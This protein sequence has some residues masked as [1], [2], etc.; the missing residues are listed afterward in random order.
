M[1]LIPALIAASIAA[2]PAPPTEPPPAPTTDA[3]D[4]LTARVDD[5]A[6]Q[7]FAQLWRDTDGKPTADQIEERYLRDGGRGVEVF[8]PYRIRN[9]EHLAATVAESP[10][11]YRNAVER[12]LPWVADTNA[13]LRASYLALR[14]L[15]PDQPLP[16][17]AVVIG[18]GNSG[19]TADTGIQVIGL[20]VLCRL[21]PTRELFNGKMRQF[22]A[23]ETVHTFQPRPS[24]EARKNPLLASALV[25]GVADYITDVVTARVPDAERDTWARAREAQV[26]RDFQHD[27]AI[28]QAGM[29]SDG[30][31]TP[32]AE[33]AY[34]RWFGNA[35][36]P[37]E[38]WPSELGYWVG[39]RIA[40]SYVAQAKDPHKAID[41][42]I[43]AADPAA[44]LADSGYG[45]DFAR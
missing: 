22:F 5:S 19:G 38:G 1:V 15:L 31:A 17:I 6:A 26:W 44:I 4:P 39:M 18:A 33:A 12:C 24:A 20:E 28:V 8:T 21:S 34:G 27:A 25:E 45:R 32:E 42:L 43:E 14:G 23:H 29:G 10:D 40:Q 30:N 3:V 37:P 36:S 13:E 9:A 41:T 7:H 11:L 2:Q 35:G 16:Q